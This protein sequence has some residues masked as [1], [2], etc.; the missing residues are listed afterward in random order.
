MYFTQNKI[1]IHT[2]GTCFDAFV[3]Y[4]KTRFFI[5][6]YIKTQNKY[7]NIQGYKS[8]TK[9]YAWKCVDLQKQKVDQEIK[10]HL[11]K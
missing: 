9:K 10:K 2:R 1:C 11:N 7:Q 5:F 8:N 6:F 3:V 4:L